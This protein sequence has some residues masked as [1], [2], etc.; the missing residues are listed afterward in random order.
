[1]TLMTLIP[2]LVEPVV[3]NKTVKVV[4]SNHPNDRKT[5]TI[6]VTVVRS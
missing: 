6:V 1:M 2:I 3:M 5:T 4:T